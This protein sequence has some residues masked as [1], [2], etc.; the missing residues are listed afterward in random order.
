ME[1]PASARQRVLEAAAELLGRG[2]LHAFSMEELATAAGVS[3]ATVYR[4]FPSK[5]A[6]FTALMR[7]YSPFESMI[8][9]LERSGEKAPAEVLPAVGRAMAV[10]GYPRLGILRHL[11]LEAS[12]GDPDAL[13]GLQP[14][15]D[16]VVGRLAAYMAAQMGAGRLRPMHPLLALQAVIGPI[17]FHLLTRAVTERM[18]GMRIPVGDVAEELVRGT[19][20]GLAAPVTDR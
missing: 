3:R 6:L 16:Q 2:G 15:L 12:T 11:I 4:L 7:A 8:D 5:A 14:L 17:A 1:P 13:S 19:L 10:D 18:M 20:S 9:V